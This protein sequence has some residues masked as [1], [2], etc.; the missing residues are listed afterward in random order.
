MKAYLIGLAMVCATAAVSVEPEQ[1]IKLTPTAP[2]DTVLT[3]ETCEDTDECCEY[4]Y[5]GWDQ[6]ALKYH[7]LVKAMA[8]LQKER[9]EG[10]AT[11]D[12][13]RAYYGYDDYGN[14]G[15]QEQEEDP[16]EPKY[17]HF[18]QSLNMKFIDHTLTQGMF[19]CGNTTV[20][21]SPVTSR[22]D[23]RVVGPW[24]YTCSEGYML[25]RYQ[26]LNDM[27]FGGAVKG[28]CVLREHPKLDPK[29]EEIQKL[30]EKAEKVNQAEKVGTG[31]VIGTV[32]VSLTFG[33]VDRL[34]PIRL[35]P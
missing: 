5:P 19:Y 24:Q 16:S 28:K 4:L 8:K 9:R 3:Q 25:Q 35:V 7:K 20:D 11:S 26:A 21:R 31:V 22:A 2:V 15:I 14:Y 1:L 17:K 6:K 18:L 33:I 30:R 34:R 12:S 32:I 23:E 27:T 10:T 29:D 13:M